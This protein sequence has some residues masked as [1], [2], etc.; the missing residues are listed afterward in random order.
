MAALRRGV[1]LEQLLTTTLEEGAVTWLSIAVAADGFEL[2]RHAVFDAGSD[3]FLDVYEFPPVDEDEYSEEGIALGTF[4][5]AP[6]AFAAAHQN[7][8]QM[9][10]WV[11]SGMVQDEYADLRS[12]R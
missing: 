3:D 9:T 2:R 10:R 11:N 7:G 5:E 6:A 12:A 4:A 8:A 1:A